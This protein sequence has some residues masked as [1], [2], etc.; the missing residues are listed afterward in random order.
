MEGLGFINKTANAWVGVLI[1]V[2]PNHSQTQLTLTSYKKMECQNRVSFINNN[3]NKMEMIL[4]L[5]LQT[6]TSSFQTPSEF[7]I[8]IKPWKSRLRISPSIASNKGLVACHSS[9]TSSPQ[10]N[11]RPSQC[12][13]FIQVEI[14]CS[15]YLIKHL[16]LMP[17]KYRTEQIL[18]KYFKYYT[19]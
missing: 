11:W 13:N 16:T 15:K 2:M 17:S 14:F 18:F 8:P 5:H 6:E 4:N 1:Y 7:S 10:H 9:A 19:I 12:W 3:R